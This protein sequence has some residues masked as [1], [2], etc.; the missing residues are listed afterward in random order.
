MS[1]IIF[2]M[3]VIIVFSDEL[4]KTILNAVSRTFKDFTLLF[5]IGQICLLLDVKNFDQVGLLLTDVE[6][7]SVSHSPTN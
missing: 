6:W 5:F 4:K 3:T 1:T 2:T 7:L